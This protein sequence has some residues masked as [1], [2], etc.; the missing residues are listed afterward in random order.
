MKA[1]K[2]IYLI[3][4]LLLLT[5]TLCKKEKKEN[6]THYQFICK[7]VAECD[8]NFKNINDIESH[9]LNFFLKLEKSKPELLKQ[10]VECINITP[11]ET[12]SFQLCTVEYIKELQNM[13]PGT[14]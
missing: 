14:N 3:I 6:D 4:L 8:K 11:C 9:C 5:I 12:L 1:F 13:K 2:F 10:I 7:K